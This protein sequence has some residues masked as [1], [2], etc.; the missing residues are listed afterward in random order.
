MDCD[1]QLRSERRRSSRIQTLP[2]ETRLEWTAPGRRQTSRGTV[3]NVSQSG[4]LVAT[5]AAP[6]M[7]AQLL[8][9]LRKPVQTDWSTARAV[10]LAEMCRESARL[11][12]ALAVDAG[13]LS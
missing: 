6:D 5:D 3:L 8:I 1:S 12:R 7:N 2:N 4:A 9:R 11:G 10:R 13:V